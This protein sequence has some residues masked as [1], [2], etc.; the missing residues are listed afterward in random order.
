MKTPLSNYL[1]LIL[2]I[3]ISF[4]SICTF[5]F[6]PDESYDKSFDAFRL[7]TPGVS[8]SFYIVFL[9]RRNWPFGRIII[10][11]FI[12]MIL[13]FISFFCGLHSYGL[14]VPFVGAIGAALIKKLF[15]QKDEFVSL[16][17]KKYLLYGFHSGLLGLVLYFLIEGYGTYGIRFGLILITWQF[18]FGM[19][20]IRQLDLVSTKDQK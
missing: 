17:E 7:L 8:F 3:A 18:A 12:L 20:W 15:Y 9:Q 1:L 16:L 6:H 10:F 11:F 2:T 13:Y 14:A 4:F 5:D 19:L